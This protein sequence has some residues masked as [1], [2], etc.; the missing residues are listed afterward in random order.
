[1]A[2]DDL[3]E[4]VRHLPDQLRDIAVAAADLDQLPDAEGIESVVVL[5]TGGARV[6]GE[7]EEDFAEGMK[8][9]AE[10]RDAADKDNDGKLVFKEFCQFIRDREEGEH[11]EEELLARFQA[12]DSDGSGK[13]DMSEYIRFSLRD[14]LQRSATRVIDLFRDWDA[15]ANGPISRKDFQSALAAHGRH[16]RRAGDRCA[17]ARRGGL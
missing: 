3:R 14:A 4:S 7:G 11:T 9:N 16:V 5:G 6:A 1:M 10:D 17:K 2:T 12:L 13:V 8:R 15:D